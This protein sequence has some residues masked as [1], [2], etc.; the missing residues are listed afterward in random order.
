MRAG[1]LVLLCLLSA[2][3]AAQDA[4]TPPKP[5]PPP[6]SDQSPFRRLDLP[7]ATTIRTGSGMP[8]RNYWQQRA[9]YVIRATLDTVERRL[10]GEETITYANNSAD[11]LRY[12]WIQLD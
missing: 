3:L 7:T 10:R 6:I 5:V 1:P 8:G 4:A 9:D 11:T 12:V 2:P